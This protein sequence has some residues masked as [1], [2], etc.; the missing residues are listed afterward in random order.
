MPPVDF[1]ARAGHVG[2]ASAIGAHS[3]LVRPS[4]G[5]DALPGAALCSGSVDGGDSDGQGE[6]PIGERPLALFA[7][8]RR[9]FR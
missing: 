9:R 5:V 1:R 4:V 2:L 8:L 7:R 6:A 3:P